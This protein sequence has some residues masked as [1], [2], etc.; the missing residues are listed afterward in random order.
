MGKNRVI[1]GVPLEGI[2]GPHCFLSLSL[3]PGYHEV[4]TPH[5]TCTGVTIYYGA[6]ATGSNYHGLKTLKL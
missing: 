4:N 1:S 5:L 6:N 3:F 2:L